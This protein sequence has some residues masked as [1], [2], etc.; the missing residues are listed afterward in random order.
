MYYNIHGFN[1][2]FVEYIKTAMNLCESNS[3]KQNLRYL[4]TISTKN[5]VGCI[6]FSDSVANNAE[7]EY[8][9]TEL[10]KVSLCDGTVDTKISGSDV[11]LSFNCVDDRLKDYYAST[12]TFRG[13]ITRSEVIWNK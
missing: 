7:L 8:F 10:T 3:T 9:Y 1:E 4:T 6:I 13:S 5:N 12:K 2:D 11:E